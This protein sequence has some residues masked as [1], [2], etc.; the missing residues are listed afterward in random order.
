MVQNLKFQSNEISV[1]RLNR[2]L[3]MLFQE[4]SAL[5][6]EDRDLPLRWSMMH[7]YSTSQMIKILAL[8]RNL[9][10]EIA[11]IIA[12]LHDYGV[13]KTKRKENHAKNAKVHVVKFIE[14]YNEKARKGL[15]LITEDELETILLAITEHSNKDVVSDNE[16]VEL[17]KDLDSFDRYLHGIPTTREHGKRI[18]NVVND[19]KFNEFMTQNYTL[20]M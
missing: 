18:E 14:R 12:A 9:D 2:I 17:M 15:S 5:E 3:A 19:L 1:K 4:I 11:G 8:K 7:M 16:Y 13:V 6:D 10:P 20:S